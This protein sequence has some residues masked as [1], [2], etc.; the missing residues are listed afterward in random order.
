MTRR[1]QM[2][3]PLDQK[4]IFTTGEAAELCN[5]SQQTIIR[6]FDNGRLNGFR[7]PGSRFRRIPRE[8]LI[9][10]MRENGMS[11]D[12]L[13]T[14]TPTILIMEAD[15]TRAGAIVES[16]GTGRRAE[17]AV[18]HDAFEAGI[19]LERSQPDLVVIGPEFEHLDPIA[20]RRRLT[21]CKG[22][23]SRIV[24]F[25]GEDASTD[26]RH[27]MRNGVDSCVDGDIDAMRILD[28]LRGLLGS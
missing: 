15:P 27:L 14:T 16:I 8:D 13:G 5:V 12:V 21:E 20:V 3:E 25:L 18:A 7:V 1:A 28:E 10:F 17:F 26:G 23:S 19:A 22:P 9:V 2:R 24:V 6:C 4:Q 11:L